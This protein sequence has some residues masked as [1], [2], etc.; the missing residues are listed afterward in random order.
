MRPLSLLLLALA[1]SAIAACKKP[2]PPSMPPGQAAPPAPTAT[3]EP[4]IP[5]REDAVQTE[6]GVLIR[7]RDGRIEARLPP[8]FSLPHVHRERQGESTYVQFSSSKDA[9]TSCTLGWFTHT[10]KVFLRID[11]NSALN[12]ATLQDRERMQ[13]RI[14]REE[15]FQF[16]GYPAR[17]VWYRIAE[18]TPSPEVDHILSDP[19]QIAETMV[20]ERS[21]FHALCEYRIAPPFFFKLSYISDSA[22]ELES[23]EARAF[24]DGFQ[25]RPAQP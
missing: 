20:K 3:P 9:H 21:G 7:S 2:A 10:E 17:R 23:P 1:A 12:I 6:Q 13:A 8:G 4:E 15:D 14:V 5:V 25:C 16:Q 11:L 22:R 19:L 18:A 24:F